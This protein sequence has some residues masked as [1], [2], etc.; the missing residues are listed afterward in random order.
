[1]KRIKLFQIVLTI[2]TA[3]LLSIN[4]DAGNEQRGGS[5]G[6]SELLINPWARSSGMGNSSVAS[7]RGLESVFMN[8]A[9]LAHTERT[10]LVFTNTQWFQGT[11]IVL[12]SFGFAQKVGEAGVMGISAMSMSFGDLIKTTSELP[13]GGIGT[14]SPNFA[15][16]TL[17]Y[18]REFSNSIYGG[19]NAKI[20]NESIYNLN[21]SGFALDAG[22]QY[23]TGFG[24]D[25]A[26]NR[27]RDN[28]RFG[29][30]MQNWGTTMQYA[31]EG[32]AFYGLS[33]NGADM[34]VEHRSQS[35][36]LPS[37]LR[38]GFAYKAL[39][40]AKVDEER[41]TVHSDHVLIIAANFTA[42]SFTRDQIHFGME[43]GYKNIM[44]L[45]GGYIYEEGITSIDN[46]LTAF[47]G[48]TAGM[49]INIPT[50]K[51][52]DGVIGIDYSYRLTNPFGGV[53]TFGA[54]VTLGGEGVDA[55]RY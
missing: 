4:V 33:A 53:H 51:D 46:R 6:A 3:V 8:V 44:Y 31:G 24:R 47:T 23:V 11:G 36:E 28:I 5:S 35:F 25:K 12:N 17:S 55:P 50:S 2:V 43:Y 29:I 37:L 39:L 38:I 10:E 18:A 49:T 54:R 22:I 52:G 34:T 27:K 19:F 7:I 20:I 1:M 16:I 41:S 40:G 30:T 48:P 26:G 32:M 21:V 14:F 15:T 9:G 42:H 13:E 45:R